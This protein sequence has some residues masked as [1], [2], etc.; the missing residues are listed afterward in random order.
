MIGVDSSKNGFLPLIMGA[1]IG[2][3]KGIENIDS[4]ILV[5]QSIPIVLQ[6][7]PILTSLLLM[8][9]SFFL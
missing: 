5:L 6:S 1:L 7:N 9:L 2:I 4:I 3:N 8:I